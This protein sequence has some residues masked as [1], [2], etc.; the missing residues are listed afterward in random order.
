[1]IIQFTYSYLHSKIFWGHETHALMGCKYSYR[2]I[3]S[4]Q[5]EAQSGQCLIDMERG[6]W[7]GKTGSFKM[8]KYD[9]SASFSLGILHTCHKLCYNAYITDF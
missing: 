6:H 5:K 1:M 9:N 7:S 8:I 2:E 4:S 3:V